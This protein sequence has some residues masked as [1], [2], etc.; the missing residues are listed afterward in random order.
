MLES[1]TYRGLDIFVP[2]RYKSHAKVPYHAKH[3]M[4]AE[5]SEC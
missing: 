5:S 1:Q 4:S 2:A 3:Y